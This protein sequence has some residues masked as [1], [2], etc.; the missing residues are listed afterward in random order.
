MRTILT[1]ALLM[2]LIEAVLALAFWAG[3]VW[4]GGVLAWPW[5]GVVLAA[6]VLLLMVVL[7][8]GDLEIDFD[9]D[10]RRLDLRFGWLARVTSREREDEPGRITRTRVLFVAWTRHAAETPAPA[11][12]R[13]ARGSGGD[14]RHSSWIHRIGDAAEPMSRA[15]SAA[16]PALHELVWNSR[17]MT[18]RVESPT[19]IGIADRALAGIIGSRRFGPLEIRFGAGA[20]HALKARYRIRLYRAALTA[21]AAFVQGRP[22]RAMRAL[23]PQNRSANP[24]DAGAVRRE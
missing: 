6:A 18:L 1:G 16:A 20:E 4:L 11:R 19:Q 14:G 10:G 23:G 24:V 8:A 9:S 21:M 7:L 5:G 3:S 22:D 13:R 17:E 15:L 2:L 12:G